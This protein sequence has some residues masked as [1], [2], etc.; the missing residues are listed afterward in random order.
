MAATLA[1]KHLYDFSR[2]D[3]LLAWPRQCVAHIE[4]IASPITTAEE[5]V[6]K[7][8]AA[9]SSFHSSV[10]DALHGKLDLAHKLS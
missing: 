10:K 4:R 8:S 5:L 2:K 6:Q 3:D 1:S 9:G 7:S